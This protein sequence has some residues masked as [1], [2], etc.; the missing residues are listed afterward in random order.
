MK[1]LGGAAM[2]EAESGRA[3]ALTR[4]P[5]VIRW[6][7]WH[8]TRVLD[9]AVFL[10]DLIVP[11]P[12]AASSLPAVASHAIGFAEPRRGIHSP[13]TWRLRG[14]TGQRGRR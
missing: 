1:P 2:N 4:C 12:A 9:G 3:P 7:T 13:G 6:L 14:R 10:G 11:L 5:P 8:A